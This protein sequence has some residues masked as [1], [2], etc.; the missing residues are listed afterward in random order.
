MLR[1]YTE[2]PYEIVIVQEQIINDFPARDVHTAM[3]SYP[4]TLA[5][6]YG[7]VFFVFNYGARYETSWSLSASQYY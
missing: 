1:S 5:I 2:T 6:L 3:K 7:I 4:Y